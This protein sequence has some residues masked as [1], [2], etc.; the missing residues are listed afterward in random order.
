MKADPLTQPS[1]RDFRAPR[2]DGEALIDPPP[3]QIDGVIDENL[4]CAARWSGTVAGLSWSELRS[5]A[6]AEVFEAAALAVAPYRD[7]DSCLPQGNDDRALP[8][9]ESTGLP[10]QWIV[11]GHQSELF[12]PGVWFKNFV[13][14][15]L[16]AH[17]RAIALNLVIDHDLCSH[18]SIQAL[19]GEA[20]QWQR[21]AVPIDRPLPSSIPLAGAI[22]YEQQP[23]SD[24]CFFDSFAAR[25]LEVVGSWNRHPLVLELWPMVSAAAARHGM[26]GRSLAEG[27]HQIEESFGLRTLEVPFSRIARSRGFLTLLA[28][29]LAELPRFQRC[30][31]DSLEEY[32]AAHGIRSAAHPVPPLGEAGQWLEAPYWIYGDDD[33]RRRSMWVRRVGRGVEI[34]D[35]HRRSL[36]IDGPLDT[37]AAIAALEQQTGAEF[38]IRPRALVTTMYARLV[39]ADLF[40]HGIGGA[41][42]DQ[43][44]DLIS[45]RF[46]QLQPPHYG[47]LS[48]TLL[49][50]TAV[51]LD[52]MPS[53]HAIHDSLRSIRFAPERFA[54]L[55]LIPA[56]WIAEKEAL[57]RRPPAPEQRPQWH[58]QI[59]RINERMQ[60]SLRE[61]QASLEELLPRAILAQRRLQSWR[62]R[63]MSLVLFSR[64]Q[65]EQ[66]ARLGAIP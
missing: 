62:S 14:S 15:S 2:G 24:R 39:L 65:L 36:R 38:K 55:G 32:K 50:P 22:P 23:I 34:S 4:R 10:P 13:L 7:L 5:I 43:L 56:E 49:L 42:Y 64:S 28:A 12:H 52:S 58:Q 44:G 31:N 27:R 63:E 66:L 21:V 54:S 51:P 48:A 18:T 60:T 19:G 59:Q 37:T 46:F 25:L 35:R 16:A 26:F 53:P 33:P 3:A 9:S 17:R 11:A 45:Q 30:Y 29:I 6:R 1:F 47:V 41:K 20:Q 40:L 61:Y 57:I 8:S